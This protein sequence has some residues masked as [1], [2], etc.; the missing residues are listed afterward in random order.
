MERLRIPAGYGF[1]KRNPR[2]E[3]PLRLGGSYLVSDKL[4]LDAEISD[5][6]LGAGGK[7][8]TSYMHSDRT[9]VYFNYA[10]ENERTDNG[11]RSSRGGEGSLVTGMKTRFSDS[12][13]IY[14]E[15]RYRHGSSMTGLTHATG[16]TLT[17]TERFNLSANTDIGKLK[18]LMTGAETDR[19]AGG[20]RIGYGVESLQLSSGIEYRDDKS[21][22]LDASVTKRQTWL[23]RNTFRWQMNPA[24]R[25]LGKLNY[26][27]SDS[28]QGTFFDGKYTEAVDGI[29]V[30]VRSETTDSTRW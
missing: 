19:V 26:S 25:L 18:D 17:P 13:S 14:L 28:S 12:T 5:G 22:Q 16:V 4:R 3:R 2:G 7:L 30:S 11:M 20:F 6:D 15:E 21:E 9:S 23:Y 27:T 1:E 8:G 10:L 24:S 29:C